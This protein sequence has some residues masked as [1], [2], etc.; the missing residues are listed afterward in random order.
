MENKELNLAFSA[1]S[2]IIK[3]FNF[4]LSIFIINHNYMHLLFKLGNIMENIIN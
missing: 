3:S 4:C 2:I 1:Y